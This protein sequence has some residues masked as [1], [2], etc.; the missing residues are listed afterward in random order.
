[1]RQLSPLDAMYLNVETPATPSNGGSVGI[2]DRS[3]MDSPLTFADLVA[4]FEERIHLIDAFRSR[5][6][7]VPGNLDQP[8]WVEDP[9]F[10]LEYHLRNIALPPPGD[11]RQLCTQVARLAARPLDLSRPPWELYLIEGLDSIEHLPA[12]AFALVI[13]FH[14]AAMDGKAAVAMMSLLHSDTLPP[15]VPPSAPADSLPSNWELLRRAGGKQLRTPGTVVRVARDLAPGAAQ[16]WRRRQHGAESGRQHTPGT[17]FNRP[18]S[19]HRSWGGVTVDLA[20][21]K[22]TRTSVPGATVGDLVVS[23]VGG[24]LRHYLGEIGELPVHSMHTMVP[25]AVHRPEDPGMFGNQLSA[26]TTTL[27]TDVADPVE[28]LRVVHQTTVAAKESLEQVGARN[29]TDLLDVIPNALFAPLYRV[30]NSA[31]ALTGPTVGTMVSGFAGPEG[32]WFL[33]GARMIHQFGMGPLV[34]GMGLINYHG[35]YDG[36]LM[37]GFTADRLAMPD[38]ERYEEALRRAFAEI[39]DA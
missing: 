17:R 30:L 37:L 9:E 29:L 11:W 19:P 39:R 33:R 15:A 4:H 38:P 23:V 24:A 10:D 7:R 27:A 14:H 22:Q 36:E 1:M 12:G 6:L 26:L 16:W 32:P 34:D 8:Y 3:E 5:L 28:R 31:Q 13:K 35:S 21:A 2:Y 18:V 25:V 20:E